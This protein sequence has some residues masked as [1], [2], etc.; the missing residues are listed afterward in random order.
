MVW[1]A[2][3]RA[4]MTAAATNAAPAVG[5]TRP[6]TKDIDIAVI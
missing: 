1:A 5:L 4:T 3:G 2:A 6:V